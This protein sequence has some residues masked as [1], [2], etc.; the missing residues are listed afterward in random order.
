LKKYGGIEDNHVDLVDSIVAMIENYLQL[1]YISLGVA[2]KGGSIIAL[3]SGKKSGLKHQ[4]R[5]KQKT[6][7]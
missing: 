1:N 6:L 2:T 5:L 7:N 3:G 4:A